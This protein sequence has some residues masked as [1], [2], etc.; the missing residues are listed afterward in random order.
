MEITSDVAAAWAQ[1]MSRKRDR[2]DSTLPDIRTVAEDHLFYLA[3]AVTHD[4]P[5]LFVDYVGWS[6]SRL[7]ARGLLGEELAESLRLLREAIRRHLP[8][9][10]GAQASAPID[11]ALSAL[12]TLPLS[13]P[14]FVD[15]GLANGRLAQA[16]LM[17]LLEG[18]RRAAA[19]LVDAAVRDGLPLKQLYLDVF[20]RSQ[21][22]IGRL[23]QL[24]RV[25]VAQEHFC[26]AATQVIMN[27]YYPRVLEAPRNGR[28]ATAF[29]VA[30]NLH[31]IGLR[32]V[33]DFLEMEGW[34]CDYIGADAPT[35]DVLDLL[36][37]GPPDLI[38]LSATMAPQVS[39]VR[40]F[41]KAARGRAALQAIPI[42][43]GGAPF[44]VSRDLWRRVGADGSASD[45]EGAVGEA[46]ALV[47]RDDRDA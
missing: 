37:K 12:E 24:N 10:A 20:Q 6:K 14:S 39:A 22:E 47:A 9:L 13:P 43:V 42:L 29:C 32:M 45:A 2:D 26:T 5:D 4:A 31:E 19:A 17:R 23:W 30:G 44:N 8:K 3:D 41:V 40:D 21:R 34:D 36:E 16:Y 15:P 25:S 27:Q 7:G 38:A 33:A 1:S 46:R 35:D 18:D 28:K 11:A